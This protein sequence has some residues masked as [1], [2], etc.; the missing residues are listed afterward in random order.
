MNHMI[1]VITSWDDT[2]ELDMNIINL[3]DKYNLKGTFFVITS[4]IDKK[5]SK[6][7]ILDISTIHEI[8]AHTLNHVNLTQVN[9]NTAKKEIEGSKYILENILNKEV[10]AF[11]YP[12]GKYDS[13]HKEIVKNSGYLC[14]RTTK[15]FYFSTVFDPFEMNVTLWSYPH[16]YKDIKA[17]FRLY[18]F[19]NKYTFRPYI[20]KQWN[21]LGKEIFDIMIK[22]GGIFHIFGHS[23]QIDEKN[24]WDKLEDLFEH[25]AYRKNVKYLTIS[26]CIKMVNGE[27]N[28][29]MK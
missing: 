11:A 15:P 21:I 4:W 3:L 6:K 25:V 26:E 29:C 23:W 24:D 9:D 22:K 27:D 19:N 16:A 1:Y 8:G 2:S 12:K 5:I 17:F 10:T 20:I 28:N 7:N 13:I 18:N 14:S